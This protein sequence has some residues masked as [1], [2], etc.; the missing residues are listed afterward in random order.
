MRHFL[1]WHQRRTHPAS[2]P[3]LLPRRVLQ[4]PSTRALV[5]SAGAP[6][7]QPPPFS[8]AAVRAVHL[9]VITIATDADRPI[10]SPASKL[11]VALLPHRVD[12]RTEWTNP[13][14]ACITIR[15]PLPVTRHRTEGPGWIGKI[16]PRA[17]A[18]ASHHKKHYRRRIRLARV[19]VAVLAGL[20]IVPAQERFE[21]ACYSRLTGS[22]GLLF[23]SKAGLFLE[24]ASGQ[25]SHRESQVSSS[26][27]TEVHS[28]PHSRPR[29]GLV[30]AG[31][32]AS[33]AGSRTALSF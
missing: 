23:G 17:F 22:P 6:P 30:E 27:R 18:P 16:V 28:F 20:Q 2:T 29:F 15:R 11:P 9:T 12:S 21:T 13:C 4:S 3:C 8:P 10:A 33:K 25:G 19:S 24:S 26:P 32:K 1:G 31:R 14:G 5:T 7:R